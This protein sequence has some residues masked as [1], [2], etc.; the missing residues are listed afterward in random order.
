MKKLFILTLILLLSACSNNSAA[1][2]HSID[3]S[4]G[5]EQMDNRPAEEP[6]GQ[7]TWEEDTMP[8]S[9]DFLTEVIPD[10]FIYPD[11]LMIEGMPANAEKINSLEASGAWKYELL[12]DNTFTNKEFGVCQLSIGQ[13][14][15]NFDLYPKYEKY[16]QELVETSREEVGY[17]TYS[18]SL[19]GEM[20]TF[21]EPSGN[22]T[23][24]LGPFY[25]IEGTEFGFG[26]ISLSNGNIFSFVLVRP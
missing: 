10:D 8:Q 18:G 15:I 9:L 20:Y 21:S 7:G 14:V 2:E 3:V 6:V 13:S 19:D 26:S 25:R 22:S 5:I 23:I 12:F 24:V 1:S 16:D 17:A 4:Q 11:R